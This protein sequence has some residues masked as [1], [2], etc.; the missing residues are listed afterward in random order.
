MYQASYNNIHNFVSAEIFDNREETT[1][2]NLIVC[3][4]PCL[5]CMLTAARLRGASQ[6]Y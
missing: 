4:D 3:D 5:L 2:Q 6:R 1:A